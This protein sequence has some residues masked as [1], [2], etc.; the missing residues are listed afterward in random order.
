[1]PFRSSAI[2]NDELIHT[3]VR[4]GHIISLEIYLNQ[5]PTC[6]NK[7]YTYNQSKWTPLLAACYYKHENIVRMLLRRFKPD[8]EILGTIV[9]DLINNQQEIIEDVSPL[10][11]AVAVDHFNIVRLLIEYGNVNINHLTK[12][13]GSIFRVACFNNNLN[14]AK[15]LVKHGANPYHVKTGS[16][17]NLMLCASRRHF[18][19][20]KY[21]INELKCNINNQDENGQTAL[22][23]AVR[24]NSY[25]IIKFLLENG[26]INIRDKLR[27]ITPL[28]RAALY[29][30]INLV[31]LFHDYCTDLEWIEANELLG[32]TFGCVARLE[33]FNKSIKYLTEAFQLRLK[34]NLPKILSNETIE[35]FNF[36]PECQTIEQFNQLISTNSK[37]NLRIE[38]IRI[39]QRLLGNMS[40]D[41]HHILRYYGAML[42]DTSRY[43]DCLCWWFYEIDLKQKYNICLKKEYLRCFINIFLEMKQYNH[44]NIPIENLIRMLKVMDNVLQLNIQYENFDYNLRTLL[45]LITIIARILFSTNKEEKQEISRNHRQELCKLIHLIIQHEYKTIK[46]GSF[47]LHLCSNSSTNSFLDKITYPCSMTVRLLL[48]C[49]ANVDVLDLNKNTPLHIVV[50]NETI[51]NEI[52][53]IINL[54]YHA[55]AH[56][57]HVNNKRQTPFELIPL[58]QNE[59]IQHLKQTIDIRSLKCICAQLIQR[60]SLSY[61]NLL[62]TSLINFIQKH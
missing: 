57:D 62:P 36:I 25:E 11:T 15:Y 31:E 8:I 4:R 14:L 38:T 30:E 42:A 6:I 24:S 56:L 16:Y 5:N 50:Q 58:F 13:Y 27:N 10:W 48:I 52:I 51:S 37:E 2:R 55:G 35:I 53:S 41:Y 19:L 28:M 1:M 9:F 49:G 61:E 22:Y 3:A 45:Y 43:N 47:L 44:M 26:A 17:T 7:I 12:T 59:V 20:V 23:Y 21:L 32:A 18:N 40:N 54:L 46:N 33:N 39:H 29:G 60:E 34:T